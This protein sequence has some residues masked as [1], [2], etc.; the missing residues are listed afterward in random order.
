MEFHANFSSL[1]DAKKENNE[2]AALMGFVPLFRFIV[3]KV[4][5][6]PANQCKL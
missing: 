2:L 5:L 1:G 3:N 6:F 4:H